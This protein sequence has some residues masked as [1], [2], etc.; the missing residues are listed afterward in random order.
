MDC[1]G[2]SFETFEVLIEQRLLR[3]GTKR[4]KI[5]ELPFRM[6]LV[7]LEKPGEV[8]SKSELT[9]RLWGEEHFV[10]TNSGLYVVVARLREVLDDD[11]VCPRFVETVSGRG[12]R[13]VVP[14]IPIKASS[15]LALTV[16]PPVLLPTPPPSHEQDPEKK[17]SP[18]FRVQQVWRVFSRIATPYLWG[19]LTAAAALCA[20]VGMSI[21]RY[22]QRPLL[23]EHDRVVIGSFYNR[24]G[25]PNLD[26]TLSSA[27]QS[28][29]QE[30]PY[31]SFIPEHRFRALFK[32]AAPAS[33]QDELR[34]C[35]TLHA[36]VLL[37]GRI[38]AVPQGYRIVLTA[39]GCSTGKLLTTQKGVAGSE[40]GVLPAIDIAVNGMRRRLGESEASLKKFSVPAV[41]A[42]TASLAALRAY[43]FATEKLLAGDRDAAIS[44]YKLATDIDQDFALAFAR[45]GMVYYNNGQIDL[46]ARSFR[47]A[48]ELRDSHASDRERLY[49]VSHYYEFATG[50]IQQAIEVN[51]LWH[52]LYP[53]DTIPIHNLAVMNVTLG[54]PKPALDFALLAIEQEPSAALHY[55]VLIQAFLIAG[56]YTDVLRLCNDPSHGKTSSVGFH[57]AC[58]DAAFASRNEVVMQRELRSVEGE[59][60]ECELIAD[61]AWVAMYHGKI[62]DSRRLFHKAQQAATRNNELDLEADIGLD[63]AMLEADVGSLPAARADVRRVLQLPFEGVSQQ[64]YAARVLARSGN[65]SE[66][67]VTAK[68]AETMAPLDDIVN[69]GMLPIARALIQLQKANPD[70]A[71]K[72]LQSRDFDLCCRLPVAEYY[73]G[74]AYLD[75]NQPALAARE[76]QAVIDHRFLSVSFSIYLV[77]AELELGHTYEILGESE[78]AK[79]MFTNVEAAWKD[80]DP[81]F[82]PLKKL[83]LYYKN[84]AL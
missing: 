25:D 15:E 46:G 20:A 47:R 18:A 71:L 75:T 23:N 81:D 62:S 44:S 50:Q 42:T 26:Q 24:T 67:M 45:L 51:Q 79:M 49:I 16:D 21:H 77:L 28:Q 38:D 5:Q 10:Q 17:R 74:L 57:R 27:I 36:Q 65:T 34:A 82:P 59:D 32:D 70:G 78:K 8:I 7:L 29:L 64:A 80:A 2:Y 84:K 53:H 13:F 56:R 43:N 60:E 69:S 55:D 30:S 19:G 14:V 72:T 11:P 48:F 6:L 12:Y 83:R 76:F 37:T 68:K 22:E 41:Q 58:F 4:L 54:R 35:A 66:A 73:R 31:L 61:S 3:H 52:S 39:T 40:S 33:L 1:Y 63:E 9:K